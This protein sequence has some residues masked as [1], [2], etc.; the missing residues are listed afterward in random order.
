MEGAS[1]S[2]CGR[3][4]PGVSAEKHGVSTYRHQVKKKFSAAALACKSPVAV[5]WVGWLV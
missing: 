4:E 1:V 2:R 5:A 3:P